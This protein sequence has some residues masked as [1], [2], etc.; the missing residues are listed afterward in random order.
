M[1]TEELHVN[2]QTKPPSA[3][4]RPFRTGKAKAS[5]QSEGIRELKTGGS[6]HENED[7]TV[8]SPGS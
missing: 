8:A 1:N 2:W 3:G 7:S 5:K 4:L 6:P